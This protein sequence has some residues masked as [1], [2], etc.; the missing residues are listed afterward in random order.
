M[1]F[2]FFLNSS[3]ARICFRHPIF[4]YLIKMQLK[5]FSILKLTILWL[6]MTQTMA[7]NFDHIRKL[8]PHFLLHRDTGHSFSN[9]VTSKI[10]HF[11]I[12]SP[13]NVFNLTQFNFTDDPLGP[14]FDKCRKVFSKVVVEQI[15][16]NCANTD[17]MSFSNSPLYNQAK[18]RSINLS[19]FTFLSFLSTLGLSTYQFAVNKDISN[20][21]NLQH[22][23][24]HFKIGQKNARNIY[25]LI[26]QQLFLQYKE[27]NNI[28]KSLNDHE[29]RLTGNE[30][31][32]II[33][34]KL[35]Q[36]ENNLRIFFTHLKMNQISIEFEYLFPNLTLCDN[37]PRKY[38]QSDGCHWFVDENNSFI[39][40]NLIIKL[41]IFDVGQ[42]SSIYK[43]DYFFNA[44]KV[45][46]NLCISQYN[47]TRYFI[48]NKNK[49]C[50]IILNPEIFFDLKQPTALLDIPVQ[51][52]HYYGDCGQNLEK[53]W[54]QV[55]CIKNQNVKPKDVVQIKKDSE[56]FYIY[57]HTFQ[58]KISES[59]DCDNVIY[60]IDHS[61][62]FRIA[63]TIYF[64]D[65]KKILVNNVFN[66]I[67]YTDFSPSNIRNKFMDKSASKNNGL[68]KNLEELLKVIEKDKVDVDNMERKQRQYLFFS[69]IKTIT[70][71][72]VI[73]LII[74]LLIILLS[75]LCCRRQC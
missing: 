31:F 61:T 8:S 21:E 50:P 32:T 5:M 12:I 2:D 17:S 4:R 15:K 33:T 57:C 30:I 71:N 29:I 9:N 63:N 65:P 75:I 34:S 73:A 47:G 55:K 52:Y 49:K 64:V 68:V 59:F 10:I 51:D 48:G 35:Y 60:R 28:S 24:H 3:C 58:L 41:I 18:K 54:H 14:T 40:I 70:S 1:A 66:T 39:E 46:D 53:F 36:I 23:F 22:E 25:S 42:N 37:C 11:M 56:Y 45:N 6:F 16:N 38:W 7:I 62:M 69:N 27:L 74:L 26:S 20:T 43:T 13:C 67:N 44:E 19:D 72:V